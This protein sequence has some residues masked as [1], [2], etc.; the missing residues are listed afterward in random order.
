MSARFN[1]RFCG[2]QNL[3]DVDFVRVGADCFFVEV[4]EVWPAGFVIVD[5]LGD[6]PEGVAAYYYVAGASQRGLLGRLMAARGTS[7]SPNMPYSFGARMRTSLVTSALKP[8]SL[9]TRIEINPD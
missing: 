2:D 1:L 4:V 6:A 3:A 9:V 8:R 7:S 5:F